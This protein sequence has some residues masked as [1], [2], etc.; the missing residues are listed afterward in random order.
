MLPSPPSDDLINSLFR[1]AEGL[2]DVRSGFTRFM[3]SD[4]VDITFG[5]FGHQ[6]ILGFG[7][8]WRVVEHV[9]DVKGRQPQVEASCVFKAPR[10]MRSD[11]YDQVGSRGGW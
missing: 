8:K 9:E 4:D 1:D 10:I 7:R 3:T 6:I 11:L 2:R 5:F